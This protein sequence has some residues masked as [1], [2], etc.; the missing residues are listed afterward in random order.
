VSKKAK[1]R[2]ESGNFLHPSLDKHLEESKLLRGILVMDVGEKDQ[3]P[4]TERLHP[5][6]KRGGEFLVEFSLQEFKKT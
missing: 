6:W 3:L 5:P 4:N 2:G 1:P